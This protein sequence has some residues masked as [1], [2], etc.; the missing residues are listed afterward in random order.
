MSRFVP[1]SVFGIHS[2]GEDDK[3]RHAARL[4]QSGYD[5]EGAAALSGLSVDQVRAI[6]DELVDEFAPA[7]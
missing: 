2:Q 6:A 3:R 1:K 4:L 7:P 5:A